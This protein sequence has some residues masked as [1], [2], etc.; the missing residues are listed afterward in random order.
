MT[1]KSNDNILAQLLPPNL[2]LD[3]LAVRMS[4]PPSQFGENSEALFLTSGYVQLS[5]ESAD[6][7][8]DV[9]FIFFTYLR[10]LDANE[11]CC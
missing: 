1:K 3:T 7:S 4:L 2:H 11:I 10:R 8:A 5:A 9:T 6:L